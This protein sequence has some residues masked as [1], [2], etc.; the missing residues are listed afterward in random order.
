MS[1]VGFDF[2]NKSC[3][4]VARQRGIDVVLNNESKRETPAIVC[5]GDKQQFLR[6]FIWL[7]MILLTIFSWGWNL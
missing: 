7:V 5:F 3:V 4:A 2:G 1:V 6:G